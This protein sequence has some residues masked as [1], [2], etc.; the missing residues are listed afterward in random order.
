MAVG[1]IGLGIMG[2]AYARHLIRAGEVVE[3][4]DPD[5]EA[6]EKL[7]D[8]GGTSHRSVGAWINDCDI[9]ILAVASPTVLASIVTDLAQVS[10]KHPVVVETGTFALKDKQQQ[11]YA[12]LSK[13]A[14]NFRCHH[15]LS[16]TCRFNSTC[17]VLSLGLT[18]SRRTRGAECDALTVRQCC[19]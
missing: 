9:I 4:S 8:L 11:E 10:R 17:N 19:R 6:R 12:R 14:D 15:K 7:E 1:I 13:I 3:G 2:S 18:T 16:G 5:A